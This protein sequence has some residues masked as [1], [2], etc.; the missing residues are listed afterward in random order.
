MGGLVTFSRRPVA[1]TAFRP[2]APGARRSPGDVRARAAAAVAT[3][4]ARARLGKAMVQA[5]QAV[6]PRRRL[7]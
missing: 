2:A 1:G 6:S 4:Q 3:I 7:H 5:S